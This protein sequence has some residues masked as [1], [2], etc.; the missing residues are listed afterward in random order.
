MERG[1]GEL[2]DHVNAG[3]TKDISDAAA[4]TIAKLG[5]SVAGFQVEGKTYALPFSLGVVGFWYNKALFEQAGISAP[6]GHVGR[7]VRRDRQAQGRGHHAA[8]GRCR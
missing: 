1:G 8:V 5:G 4:E 2:R 3:I 6:P 7:D